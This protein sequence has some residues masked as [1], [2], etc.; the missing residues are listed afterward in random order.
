M[1]LSDRHSHQSGSGNNATQTTADNQPTL[2]LSTNPTQLGFTGYFTGLDLATPLPDTWD[3]LVVSAPLDSPYSNKVL[4][5]SPTGSVVVD[6]FENDIQAASFESPIVW[7]AN[8][9][10]IVYLSIQASS[11]AISMNGQAPQVSSASG[12]QC[13]ATSIGGAGSSIRERLRDAGISDATDCRRRG[14]T[15]S[16]H[17]CDVRYCQLTV[18]LNL[19]GQS[20]RGISGIYAVAIHTVRFPGYFE[21]CEAYKHRCWTSV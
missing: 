14:D 13:P 20:R 8:E 17:G 4:L 15:A 3:L 9:T 16:Q 1:S 12:A 6:A 7:A 5:P 18:G 2:A 10:A 11:I 19:S 21:R